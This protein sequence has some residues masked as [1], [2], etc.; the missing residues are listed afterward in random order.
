MSQIKFELL[1]GVDG[2]AGR[3]EERVLKLFIIIHMDK[4]ESKKILFFIAAKKR[5]E[6]K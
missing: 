3:E 1:E 5:L 6:I 2:D 4:A